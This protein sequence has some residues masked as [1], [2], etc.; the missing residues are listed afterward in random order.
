MRSLALLLIAAVSSSVAHGHRRARKRL[1]TIYYLVHGFMLWQQ[2]RSQ[3]HWMRSEAK[4][5]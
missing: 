2:Y 3:T 4:L 1:V 5:Q